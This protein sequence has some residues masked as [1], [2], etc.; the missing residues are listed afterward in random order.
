MDSPL[1]ES[2]GQKWSCFLVYH[3]N[4]YDLKALIIFAASTLWTSGSNTQAKLCS[5]YGPDRREEGVAPAKMLPPAFLLT[6]P[7]IVPETF[8]KSPT[9]SD[10]YRHI[11][12]PEVVAIQGI[13]RDYAD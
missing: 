1:D 2:S 5:S 9:H 4:H 3:N 8:R 6:G 11:D 10:I 7:K 13:V 12:K